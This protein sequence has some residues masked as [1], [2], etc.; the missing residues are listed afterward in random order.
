MSKAKI[1]FEL[2]ERVL[3]Q[4][5]AYAAQNRTSLSKL[6]SAFFAGLGK[7]G[8]GVARSSMDAAL[9]EV[10]VGKVSVADAARELGLQDVG[11][12]LG[13]MREKGLPLPAIDPVEVSEQAQDSFEALKNTMRPGPS[14]PQAKKPARGKRVA[15]G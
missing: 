10:A 11:H 5:Q 3:A 15:I 6:V 12:L 14:A 4:A 2:D 1:N 7:Q 13:I 8:P 9:T